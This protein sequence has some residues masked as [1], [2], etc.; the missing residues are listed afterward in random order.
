MPKKLRLGLVGLGT[1]AKTGHLP[2]YKQKHIQSILHIEALCSRDLSKARKWASSYGVP[3]AYDD[4]EDMLQKSLVDV[5]AVC[6]PDHI[7]TQY[8][9]SALDAGCHV[10]VEKPLALSTDDCQAII[11]KCRQTGKQV[12]VLFHKRADALWAE[13]AALIQSGKL[14]SLQMGSVSIQN[15]LTVSAG[16]YFQSNMVENTTPN[17]FLGTHMYDLLRFMTNE[18]PTEVKARQ[19]DGELKSRGFNA[20]DAIKAD[21]SFSGGGSISFFLSWNLPESTPTITRQEMTLHFQKGELQLDG[22]KRGFYAY[23]PENYQFKNPYFLRETNGRW[24][25]YG[26]AY[27]EEAV[28]FLVNDDYQ[29]ATSLATAMDGYWASALAQAVEKSIDNNTSEKISP[30]EI[31]TQEI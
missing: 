28:H 15:S 16:S 25:G 12:I 27:L 6:T 19:Y 13:A 31:D 20:P 18:N 11:D 26:A 17:W 21:V 5:I 30:P 7:H 24:L 3:N 22:S 9:L 1:W 10:L 8:V 29:P 4:F 2:I 23:T 14:G